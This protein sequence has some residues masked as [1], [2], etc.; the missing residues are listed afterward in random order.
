MDNSPTLNFL[1]S[2]PLNSLIYR[3]VYPTL[4]STKKFCNLNYDQIEAKNGDSIVE[5]CRGLVI[6]KPDGSEFSSD[7]SDSGEFVICCRPIKRFYN[8]GTEFASILDYSKVY[9]MEKL[10]GSFV[11]VWWDSI[12]NEWAIG[13]RG[14]AKANIKIS[15]MH[16]KSEFT[17][18]TL[19]KSIVKDFAEF[20]KELDKEYTYMFELCSIWNQV[21][22]IHP[23]PFISLLAVVNSTTGQELNIWELPES[24]FYSKVKTYD[25]S[26]FEEV[27][28][29]FEKTDPSK[30][31]GF[32]VMDKNFNRIKVKHPGYNTLNALR[33]SLSSTRNILNLILLETIDDAVPIVTEDIKK[34]IE[35]LRDATSEY[36]RKNEEIWMSIKSKN[37]SR[38]EFALLCQEKNLPLSLFMNLYSGKYLTFKD[39]FILS[40]RTKQ[41]TYS[42]SYL[43]TI[44]CLVTKS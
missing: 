24:K 25:F 5:E 7:L 39:S 44:Y 42:D 20:K 29:W 30:F 33:A 23:E 6:R 37:L 34:E 17:F 26:S 16:N 27:F 38:K 40:G 15:G 11:K 14:A 12:H 1:L 13:T 43:D 2:N 32:V 41:G 8:Y 22:I 19:F 35:K 4:D 9:Y 10:D 18:T 31:E 3:G 21:V 36:I 28:S